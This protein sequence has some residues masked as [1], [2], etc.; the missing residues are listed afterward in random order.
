MTWFSVREAVRTRCSEGQLELDE[1][2]DSYLLCLGVLRR[3]KWFQK[4]GARWIIRTKV[5]GADEETS[6]DWQ[7]PRQRTGREVNYIFWVRNG[8]LHLRSTELISAGMVH[9]SDWEESI[10]ILKLWT[11]T[12]ILLK[13]DVL[14]LIAKMHQCMW[15]IL[16][17]RS[18]RSSARVSGKLG[19]KLHDLKE[20]TERNTDFE[21][22]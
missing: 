20:R 15:R 9:P 21:S 7:S 11:F 6:T 22:G 14:R 13:W 4:C 8:V 17:L 5:P 12:E 10:C 18:V 16:F 3:R 2:S 1:K 19:D